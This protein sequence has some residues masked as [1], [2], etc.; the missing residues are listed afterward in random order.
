M[1]PQSVPA[2]TRHV[3]T[4]QA[5]TDGS[6]RKA[7]PNR[8][9]L[10]IMLFAIGVSGVITLALLSAR[11]ESSGASG[12]AGAAPGPKAAET[13]QPEAAGTQTW[14]ADNRAYW[15]GN[16]PKSAAFELPAENTVQIWMRSVRPALI[17]RCM[18]QNM[19]VFV[20]TESAMKIEPQTEDHTVTFGFDGEPA[21]TERWPDSDEHDSL[22][23]PDGTAF[24]QRL[25]AARTLRVG[26]TP[27]NAD[28]VVAH[29]TVSGLGPLLEPVAK[30]CGWKK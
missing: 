2:Q 23:A 29:F 13:L 6:E 5:R 11:G 7:G 25:M 10:L 1:G 28:P 27:H 22:F 9:E 4:P 18:S 30:E 14:S 24:A 20:V 12:S 16:R 3:G 15:V 17:V 19:Q 26:Y 21:A 8:R